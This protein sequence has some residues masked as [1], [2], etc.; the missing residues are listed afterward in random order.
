MPNIEAIKHYLTI[1]VWQENLES[2]SSF[3]NRIAGILRGV[4]IMFQEATQ[5]D[6]KY[7]AMGLVYKTLLSLAP[8]LAV[9][10]SV[11]KAFG[12]HNQL[13]PLLLSLLEP[14]GGR[15][16]EL[17]G[18]FIGYVENIHIGVL[19]AAGLG[20]LLY[21]AI[22]LLN[23]LEEC[24]N[25][26]WRV[27]MSRNWI[28]RS[29]DY[30]SVLLVGPVL[31][32]S[33]L[34]VMASMANNTLVQKIIAL[35]PFGS[36]YY[37]AGLILPYVLII[38]ALTFLYIFMPNTRVNFVS[39]LVG[40]IV[41]GLTW[42]MG[43]RLFGIFVEES[44]SYNAIYSSF[45]IILLSMIWLYV[46]WLIVL[47]GGVVSFLHQHPR[48]LL[49]KN[50]KPDLNHRQQEYFGFLILFLIGRAYY[51]GKSPWTVH[52]LADE[53]EQPWEAIRSILQG[54]EKAGFVIA[55][56]TEPSAYLLA[57]AP[58]TISLKEIYARLRTFNGQEPMNPLNS[59]NA[60]RVSALTNHIEEAA[61][62]VLED[63]TLSDLIHQPV[64]KA[65]TNPD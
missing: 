60:E 43:G 52:A 6:L 62:A 23:I 11:L 19:G 9:S 32:F 48:Y 41:A 8:L 42:K 45:A 37:L 54:L 33:A 18:Q 39:A 47:L 17:A 38:A 28:H 36:F 56:Q 13:M 65:Q 20:F 29:S 22:S 12:V 16:A 49:H 61:M 1:K 58:E 3:S 46:S 40:G 50:K 64:P 55:V 26:I 7:R 30:M 31:V 15:G 5:D 59:G 27:E 10:F 63:Q 25:R 51:E 35:E 2:R 34:G 21:S 4:L 24:F 44:T 57:R 14:L 53:I